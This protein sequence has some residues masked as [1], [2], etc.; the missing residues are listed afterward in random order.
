MFCCCCYYEH[1]VKLSLAALLFFHEISLKWMTDMR[2]MCIFNTNT[3][4][5]KTYTHSYHVCYLKNVMRAGNDAD[6]NRNTQD[7]NETDENFPFLRE[8]RCMKAFV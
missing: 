7:V 3:G 8:M 5:M 2:R 6:L 4:T 1:L